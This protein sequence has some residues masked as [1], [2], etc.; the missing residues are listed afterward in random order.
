MLENV[1]RVCERVVFSNVQS[2]ITVEF[3]FACASVLFVL[4]RLNR[5]RA[6]SVLRRL[7]PSRVLRRWGIVY[8]R[9]VALAHRSQVLCGAGTAFSSVLWRWRRRRV[10]EASSDHESPV[11]YKL[12]MQVTDNAC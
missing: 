4:D 2:C 12:Q 5:S 6:C 11:G 8:G 7:V 9:S 3:A 10:F 1:R